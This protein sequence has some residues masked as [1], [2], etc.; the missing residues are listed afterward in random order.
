MVKCIFNYARMVTSYP[1]LMGRAFFAKATTYLINQ[2]NAMKSC[3][4]ICDTV[5]SKKVA[6]SGMDEAVHY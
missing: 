6:A 2:E 1:T 4:N 3:M 5:K